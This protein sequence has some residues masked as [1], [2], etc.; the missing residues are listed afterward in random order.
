VQS[1]SLPLAA[2][3]TS[4][5]KPRGNCNINKKPPS[6]VSIPAQDIF[7]HAQCHVQSPASYL[8][9]LRCYVDVTVKMYTHC[10]ETAQ[11]RNRSS[12]MEQEIFQ[13]KLSPVTI[14]SVVDVRHLLSRTS[15]ET[16]ANPRTLLESTSNSNDCAPEKIGD[17]CTA[18]AVCQQPVCGRQLMIEVTWDLDLL[19]D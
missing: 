10:V 16:R 18:T 17:P 4:G 19:M 15:I 9:Q 11:D 8:T 7:V 2:Y 12:S 14:P 5:I 13:K 3:H 1:K 6:G